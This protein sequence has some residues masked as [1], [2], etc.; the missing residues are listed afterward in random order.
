MARIGFL[1]RYE[2]LPEFSAFVKENFECFNLQDSIVE[3]DYIFSAP[4]YPFCK[5]DDNIVKETKCK[6]VITPSTG[7]NHILTDLVPVLSIKKDK[8]LENITSTAE[9]NLYLIL[10]LLRNLEP[11]RQASNLTLGILGYGR[12]GKILKRICTPIFKDIFVKD[13][14]TEDSEF[15]KQ[16]DVLSINVDLNPTTEDLI[17][18]DYINQFKK[19]IFIVN[20]S[21]GEI[22]NEYELFNLLLDG[23]VIGYATD[24]IKE[25]HSAKPTP[26]K[27][28]SDKR[29]LITP[30]VGGTSIE[31][32]EMAYKH[33]IKKV[34]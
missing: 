4:N 34:L 14:E 16:T 15:F 30:H 13:I 31:A 32:Q 7:T 18:V 8:I 33:V 22:V 6:A 17:N 26:L 11:R 27:I 25:E 29:V 21:R 20:T 19:A 5:V 9:H 24:V 12:L 28:Y 2:H 10:Y 1:T 3:V 23:K